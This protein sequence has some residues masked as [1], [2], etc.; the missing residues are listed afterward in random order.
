MN[1][2]ELLRMDGFDAAVIGHTVNLGFPVLVY[3]MDKV[4]EILEEEQGMEPQEASGY[5]WLNVAGAYVG[6]N[7]PMIVCLDEGD[8]LQNDF[9]NARP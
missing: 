5:F 4:L 1:D 6:P 7:T 8:Y 3:D 9:N 2:S